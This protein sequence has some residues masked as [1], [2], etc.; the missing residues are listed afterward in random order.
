MGIVINFPTKGDAAKG[1]AVAQPARATAGPASAPSLK[2]ERTRST[3]FKVKA[4]SLLLLKGIWA[5][6]WLVLVC[7]WPVGRWIATID[8]SFQLIR[9]AYYWNTP[10]VYAGWTFLLHFAVFTAWIYLVG[11]HRPAGFRDLPPEAATKKG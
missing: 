5:S 1:S 8:L 3:G 9:T 2:T 11:V 7:L 6:V 4:I 10:H